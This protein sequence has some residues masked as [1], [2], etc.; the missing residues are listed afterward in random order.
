MK[1][2]WSLICWA[3]RVAVPSV[4]RLGGEVGE[5]ALPHRIAARAGVEHDADQHQRQVALLGDEEDGAVR[6]RLL[7]R[8]RAEGGAGAERGDEREPRSGGERHGG[9]AIGAG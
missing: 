4:T 5:A 7:R 9:A 8:L 3:L 1:S 2:I 6:E